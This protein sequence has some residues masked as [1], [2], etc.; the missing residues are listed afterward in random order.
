MLPLLPSTIS[1]LRFYAI[2][3]DDIPPGSF[4]LPL[5]GETIQF[6]AAINGCKGSYAFVQARRLR[7]TILDQALEITFK[8]ICRMLM[9]LEDGRKR[10]MLQED[11]THGCEAMLESP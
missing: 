10:D 6:M 3:K 8:A 9:S 5:I 4:G 7:I 11:I 2:A 1:S